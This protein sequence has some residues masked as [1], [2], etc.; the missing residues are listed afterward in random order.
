M[1][2]QR[3]PERRRGGLLTPV[4]GAIIVIVVLV[5]VIAFRVEVWHFLQRAGR[6]IG[7]WFTDWVPDHQGA[8]AAILG[9][10]VVAF[11]LNW[12]AHVRGRLRAWIFALVVEIGLW[13]L[14]WYSI[15]VPSLNELFGFDIP[16]LSD[17]EIVV[18]GIVVIAVTGL[19]FWWLEAR[20]EWRQYR[21]RHDVVDE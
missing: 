4:L 16:K 3:Y 19:L 11:V 20:E 2:D 10:A 14:F 6:V 15:G 1:A 21:H 7:G 13:L 12:L 5:A 17:T 8:T 18:S 9:F